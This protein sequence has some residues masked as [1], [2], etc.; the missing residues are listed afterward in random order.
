M[1]IPND[2]GHGKR[3]AGASRPVTNGVKSAN[4]DGAM[5]PWS[6]DA[7]YFDVVGP[8]IQAMDKLR[9][10]LG[11]KAKSVEDMLSYALFPKVAL[12]FFAERESGEFVPE[13]TLPTD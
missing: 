7:I 13:E 12:Q 3:G 2:Q 4:A 8:M 1:R 5:P 9:D 6:D 10:E 11:D